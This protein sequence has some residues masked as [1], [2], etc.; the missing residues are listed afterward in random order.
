MNR[1]KAEVRGQRSEVRG[2]RS[3]VR[4]QRMG[5]FFDRIYKMNRIQT[6]VFNR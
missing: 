3:E 1:I 6:L 2:Q 4:E 5:F